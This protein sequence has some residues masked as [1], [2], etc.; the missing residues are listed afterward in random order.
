MQSRAREAEAHVAA[1]ANQARSQMEITRDA[2]VQT[3][4]LRAQQARERMLVE[5]DQ[6]RAA[7]T[8]AAAQAV[9]SLGTSAQSS[10]DRIAGEGAI[11]NAMTAMAG[12]DDHLIGPH[13]LGRA[14]AALDK[15]SPAD[16][17][18]FTA[19][20]QSA[21]TDEERAVLLKAVV[22]GTP[23]SDVEWL[24]TQVRG[25]NHAWLLSQTTLSDPGMTGGGDQQQYQMTCGAT[26]V[27]MV[28]GTYDP[29]Y[30]LRMHQNNPNMGTVNP[31]NATAVN[32][33][34][35]ADQ[36]ALQNQNYNGARGG[37]SGG[38]LDPIN[39][40]NPSPTGRF[41]DDLLTAQSGRTGLNY[42]PQSTTVNATPAQILTTFDSNLDDGRV[43]PIIVGS[44]TAN[45]A[46]YVIAMARR[47]RTDGRPGFEYQI[48]DPGSG[49]T[50]WQTDDQIRTGT[51]NFGGYPQIQNTEVP[52]A[53][54]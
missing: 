31:N 21:T 12:M 9:Q 49:A 3:I 23:M 53:V 43:V 26:T 11:A 48:H 18:R 7:A 19:A 42:A 13:T 29:V 45:N 54:P 41:N 24:G 37:M 16:H 17:A 25:K 10:V 6:A 15:L 39:S 5:G 20:M 35:A 47:P 27:E 34:L 40:A 50:T 46:H 38:S 14:N 8:K 44:P 33:N 4:G 51:G 2:A 22:S 32:P 36:A 28:R 30:A 1:I 52:T